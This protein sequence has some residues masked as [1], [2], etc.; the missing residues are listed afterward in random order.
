MASLSLFC[1][2]AKVHAVFLRGTVIVLFEGAGEVIGG[3]V[4]YGFADFLYA[5]IA[6]FQIAFGAS[7]FEFIEQ[8]GKVHAGV[9]AD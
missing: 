3:A 2:P 5:Q 1:F 8:G 9:L 6:G 4:A 7:G